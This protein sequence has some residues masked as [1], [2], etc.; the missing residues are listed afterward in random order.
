MMA[1]SLLV[2]VGMVLGSQFRKSAEQLPKARLR[3]SPE[4]RALLRSPQKLGLWLKPPLRLRIRLKL[5]LRLR[6]VLKLPFLS[7][8][9][10]G[11]RVVRAG[12]VGRR[13]LRS[14]SLEKGRAKEPRTR[15][16][17]RGKTRTLRKPPLRR[18]GFLRRELR[19]ARLPS[20]SP[21]STWRRPSGLIL[22]ICASPD[23]VSWESCTA[24]RCY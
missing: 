23:C 1:S 8:R 20:R 17:A 24:C 21:P 10:A 4:S 6:I 12:V 22:S 14:R 11:E 15:K 19:K 5:P 7:L 18:G 2:L 3:R 13:R 9:R 16:R